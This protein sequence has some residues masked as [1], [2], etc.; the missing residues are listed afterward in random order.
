MSNFNNIKVLEEYKIGYVKWVKAE[1]SEHGTFCKRKADFDKS[2]YKCPQ[3]GKTSINEARYKRPFSEF[4]QEAKKIHGDKYIYPDLKEFY[5]NDKIEIVCP[6]HGKFTQRIEAH[7]NGRGCP[8]CGKEKQITSQ[9]LSKEEIIEKCKEVSPEYDYS[10]VQQIEDD[11]ITVIC[12]KHGEWITRYHDLLKGHKCPKCVAED[13]RFKEEEKLKSFLKE[14]YGDDISF[15]KDFNYVNSYIKVKVLYKGEEMTKSPKELKRVVLLSEQDKAENIIKRGLEKSKRRWKNIEDELSQIHNNKYK[16]LKEELDFIKSG[17]ADRGF[18]MHI[19]CP[20]HGIFEQTFIDHRC[21]SGC[22]KCGEENRP[23]INVSKAEK[24]IVDLIKSFYDGEII[25][26]DRK[27]LSGKELDIYL[28]DLNLAI[29]YDGVYWHN[30]I[31]NYFK[32]EECNKQGIRLI[33]ISDWEWENQN[34]KIK[35]YLKDTIAK[36][37]VKVF[38]RNCVLKEIDNADYKAFCEENHLQG[39]SAASVRIGL[40]Y[41]NNLFQIMSFSK[42]HFNKD[43]EWEMIR[44]CS[45]LGYTIIGGK[46][47][48]LKYFERNYKPKNLISYCEKNKFSGN[49]YLKLGFKLDKESKPGYNYYK[50]KQKLARQT[51]QKHKLK[52]LLENFDENLTEWENMTRNHYLKLFDY[53]NYVFK[54]EYK[55]D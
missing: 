36:N 40:F 20:K 43:C 3:C 8:K 11:K 22:R 29:E 33:Q 48:L 31:N 47:K 2:R 12:P 23:I 7:L 21:G 5:R 19:E 14:K 9:R 34:E 37:T 54:K 50:G 26:N 18:K 55:Y 35:Q 51:C 17:N 30:C 16:Y 39:Y 13:K 28:P 24:E 46:G 15:P 53:G 45:R 52:K 27:I 6:I 1:C 41:E 44:E 10:K 4:L 32:F 38:A 49:S 42:P 25:V